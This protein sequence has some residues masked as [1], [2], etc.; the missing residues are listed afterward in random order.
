[1]HFIDAKERRG[2]VGAGQKPSYSRKL[3]GIRRNTGTALKR[4]LKNVKFASKELKLL[5]LYFSLF[6]FSDMPMFLH[7]FLLSSF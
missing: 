3:K 6:C 1:M 4:I 5:F 7:F 2:K